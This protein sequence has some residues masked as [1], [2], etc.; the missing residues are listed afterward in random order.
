MLIDTLR[1]AGIDCPS[2]KLHADLTPAELIEWAL[3]RQ[4]GVL[5]RNGSLCVTTGDRTGRSPNDR[6]V[7][8]DPA[9]HDRVA[10]G[11]VNVPMDRSHFE[12]IRDRAAG[13]LSDRDLF[14]VRAFAGADRRHARRV[15]VVCERASQALFCHQMLVRPTPDEL[16]SFGAPD[17]LVLAAPGLTCVP[18]RDATNSDA[19]VVLDLA[20]GQVLVTGTAYSGEIKKAV[21]SFMNWLLPVE[22]GVL[23]MHCSANMDRATGE[24]AVLFGLSGTGKTT[25]SADPFRSLIGDDEHGWS[26]EGVFNIEGGCYAKTIDLSPTAE[27]Q[28]FDAIR[29]GSICENVVVGP[30]SRMPDYADASLTENTRVAYPVEHIDDASR[31][32]VGQTPSVILFLA[33][34]AF[35]VLPPISRLSR[36]GAMYHFLMGFTSKVAGTEQGVKTPQPTFSALFGEPFMPLDPMEYANMLGERIDRYHTNV[37]LVNTG[38]TGGPYGVGRRIDLGVT[39]ALVTAALAGSIGNG[40][41]WHDERLN[42]DVP[43]DCP[44]VKH[45]MLNPANTW[46]DKESYDAAALTLAEIFDEHRRSQ[47]PELDGAVIAAGPRA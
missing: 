37:Y 28:I 13:R 23:P 46:T 18:E 19:A 7:V 8:D 43:L 21:F 38:W 34:D 2:D 20:G 35:G 36:E 22:D 14:I 9:I 3:R 4:E 15:M 41:W 27:P 6:F 17:I 16:A 33:C 29:F 45:A 30:A 26:D 31:S 44:F 42:L 25:L 12:S 39:R 47:Y 1:A 11:K 5:A 32:G 10:W 40:G 24:T